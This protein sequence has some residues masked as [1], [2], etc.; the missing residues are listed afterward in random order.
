MIKKLILTVVAVVVL[1][2]LGVLVVRHY[3]QYK[4]QKAQAQATASKRVVDQ[5]AAAQNVAALKEAQLVAD[6][7]AL[8]QECQKGVTAYG[9]LPAALKAKLPAPNCTPAVR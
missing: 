3:H 5:V 4:N 2:G 6:Y 9:Q 1:A 7:N 8:E